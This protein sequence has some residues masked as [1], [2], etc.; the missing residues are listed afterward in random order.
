MNKDSEVYQQAGF[1]YPFED[2][3]LKVAAHWRYAVEE[4][5]RQNARFG[6]K[7][8]NRLLEVTYEDFCAHT[9]ATLTALFEFIGVKPDRLK[10][11]ERKIEMKNQ[12]FKWQQE[13]SDE[14]ASAV[15]RIQEP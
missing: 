14:L 10:P 15:C 5:S 7:D 3:L 4:V 12:N 13:L 9:D 8:S 11:S 2:V 6:L 1:D